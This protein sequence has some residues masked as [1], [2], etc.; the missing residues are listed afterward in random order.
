MYFLFLFYLEKK[1][2]V[3]WDALISYKDFLSKILQDDFFGNS[4]YK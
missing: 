1:K 2:S 3:L 4:K